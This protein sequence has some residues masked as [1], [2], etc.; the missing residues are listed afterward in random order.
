[1]SFF[2]FFSVVLLIF[3]K[4]RTLIHLLIFVRVR[5]AGGSPSRGARRGWCTPWRGHRFATVQT[6]QPFIHTF[7]LKV[8][9][10]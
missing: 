5:G 7:R 10:K 6:Q 2:S 3:L 4:I 9:L 8:N 1:M